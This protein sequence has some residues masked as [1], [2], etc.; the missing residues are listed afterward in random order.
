MHLPTQHQRMHTH[1][2]PL[3]IGTAPK[4]PPDTSLDAALALQL[5]QDEIDRLCGHSPPDVEPSN[6]LDALIRSQLSGSRL[7]KV[8]CCV[9]RLCCVRLGF[10]LRPFLPPLSCSPSPSH[11]PFPAGHPNPPPNV[12]NTQLVPRLN[13]FP[14]PVPGSSRDRDRQRLLA[15]LEL[16]GLCEKEVLGDGNCLFRALSDQL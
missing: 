5:H 6:T 11:D 3:Y 7:L 1:T 14:S 8:R 10:T 2:H 4:P 13:P 15:R 9:P 12:N 16:Y